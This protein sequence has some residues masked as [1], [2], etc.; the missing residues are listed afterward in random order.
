MPRLPAILPAGIALLFLLFLCAPAAQGQLD[1]PKSKKKKAD[2][3]AEEQPPKREP[4]AAKP[5]TPGRGLVPHL[6]CATCGTHNYVSNFQ[7][8][9]EDGNYMAHCSPCGR[10]MKHARAKDVARDEKLDLPNG[11]TPPSL[12]PGPQPDGGATPVVSPVPQQYGDGA[13]AFIL[14]QVAETRDLHASVV[15]QAVGS[16]W[17]L[18]EEGLHAAR[19][20]LYDPAA[21]VVLVAGRVLLRGGHGEDAER[22]VKRLRTAMPGKSGPLLLT[23]LYKQ[24]PVH[25]SPEL[26]AE[27][28]DHPMQPMRALAARLFA[29]RID[30]GTLPLLHP[31]LLSKRATTRFLALELVA[32]VDDPAV[33]EILLEHLSDRSARAA[34]FAAEALAGLE[35]DRVPLE[36]V[37]RAFNS[38]WILRE[39]AYA[40]LGLIDIE[41]RRLTAIL[42]E[43][44]VE[45][46]LRGMESNDLF[47]SGSCAAALAGIGFRSPQPTRTLWLDRDV[48]GRLV[49][50]VSGKEYHNDF[51]SVQSRALNRLRRLSGQ[52]F[53]TDGPAWANWWIENRDGFYAHRAYLGVPP[54]GE[55]MLEIHYRATG[56]DAGA[57]SLMGAKADL[58]EAS[59]RVGVAES[60]LLTDHECR[61]LLSLMEREGVLGPDR[62][63]GLRGRRGSGQR[64][65]EILVGGRGKAFVFGPGE[66]EAWFDRL[67]AALRDLRDRNRW[68][69][70]ADLAQFETPREFWEVEAGWWA[71]ERTELEHAVRLKGLILS[72]V[73]NRPPSQRS[74]AYR[75]LEEVFG[76]EGAVSSEDFETLLDLLR[77]EGFFAERVRLLV[78][79]A[80]QA[81]GGG[82]EAEGPVDPERGTRLIQLLLARFQQDAMPA[83]G[84]TASACGRPYVREL[85]GDAHPILRAVAAAELSRAPDE[86]D[87]EILMG[88]L[89]DSEP[90]VET[91]AV[92]SLGEGRVEDS[93]TEL[94]LRARMASPMVR[95][96]ALRSVGKLGGEYVLEALVLGVADSDLEVK[97]GAAQGL[98]EL[99]DPQSAPLL[100]SLLRRD[101]EEEVYEAAR[102][103]LKKLGMVAE[104]DLLRV[105]QS[106]AHHARLDAAIL[107][108][109]LGVAEVVPAMLDLL[110]SEPTDPTLGFELA[111]LS[112]VDLRGA[113]DPAGAWR[114]WY[115]EVTHTEAQL[116]LF[117]AMERRGRS[118]PLS[119]E[120]VP[121][122]TRDAAL[123]LLEAMGTEEDY[124]AERGRRELARM[125]ERDLG[126]APSLSQERAAWLSTLRDSVLHQFD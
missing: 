50:L 35:N 45:S 91:A 58:S 72:W 99:A 92:L 25:G 123:F 57:F 18:G 29:E 47:V 103:G 73:G 51:S 32:D 31:P 23:D 63:P 69:R 13:A 26:L 79:L 9:T 38:R 104:P 48:T 49:S 1:L 61:D 112:C 82:T 89:E 90:V 121:P 84:R 109:Q 114:E 40:L 98:A 124:L 64:T 24:D 125:L 75:E 117:A 83:M 86:I 87:A 59:H 60:F 33:I 8:P 95:A 15:H 4:P 108:S 120:F 107:L 41:E 93:R 56:R 77:D 106:P 36:L 116:W 37:A 42:D 110:E 85:A 54:E 11:Q 96:A 65:I 101:R 122:G 88:L 12:P 5:K 20:A 14:A 53:G 100:I 55:G 21:T 70:F 6:V 94:L 126:E 76:V 3:G 7:R 66:T 27:M 81:A 19:R 78:D 44:H 119:R 74:Y 28:L 22:L 62:V 71:A 80:L 52:D 43:R 39:N 67:G 102:A 68:Q 16:L 17:G 115:D 113:D 34:S 105:V 30:S 97:R 111:T 10:D 46:L 118:A 2:P